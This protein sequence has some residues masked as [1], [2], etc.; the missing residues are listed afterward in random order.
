MRIRSAPYRRTRGQPVG[1]PRTRTTIVSF[2]FGSSAPFVGSD[3]IACPLR[4]GAGVNGGAARRQVVVVIAGVDHKSRTRLAHQVVA[5]AGARHGGIA[6]LAHGSQIVLYRQA[7]R[8][9]GAAIEGRVRGLIEDVVG[10]QRIGNG[11]GG[12]DNVAVAV[13]VGIGEGVVDDLDV[14]ERTGIELD[15][16][17]APVGVENVVLNLIVASQGDVDAVVVIL[18]V[19]SGGLAA[20]FPRSKPADVMNQIAVS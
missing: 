2:L 1:R 8:S 3:V 15:C 14:V 13:G 16:P 11:A 19:A 6:H 10:N 9:A 18:V 7:I 20:V 17:A 4:G 5:E 12:D